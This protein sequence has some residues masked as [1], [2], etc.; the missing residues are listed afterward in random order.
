MFKSN[1]IWF[2]DWLAS[3]PS[4]S[5]LGEFRHIWLHPLA[6]ASSQSGLLSVYS[7]TWRVVT[8]PSPEYQT[9]YYLKHAT[10]KLCLNYIW[11]HRRA[12]KQK[13]RGGRLHLCCYWEAF[14]PTGCAFQVWPFGGEAPTCCKWPM[15]CKEVQWMHCFPKVNLKKNHASVFIWTL[16]E[17]TVKEF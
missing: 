13:S 12:R 1:F 14:I 10:T 6:K 16:G 3:R 7:P 4:N 5:H 8:R 2:S 11:P 17:V 9:P 15:L